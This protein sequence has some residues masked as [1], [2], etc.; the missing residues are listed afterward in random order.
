[1]KD[2][3]GKEVHVPVAPNEE[4]LIRNALES[5]VVRQFVRLQVADIYPQQKTPVPLA[6]LVKDDIAETIKSLKAGLAVDQVNLIAIQPPKDVKASFDEVLQ[7]KQQAVEQRTRADQERQQTLIRAAGAVG[8]A[9]GDEIEKWWA[10]K[11]A[12]NAE[13]VKKSDAVI[14]KLFL[15]AGGEVQATESDISTY[16]IAAAK[17]IGGDV[18]NTISDARAY[19]IT[20]VESARGDAAQVESLAKLLKTSPHEVK[21]FLDQA[22]VEA[23]QE[24]L[25]NAYETY[26]YHSGAG[27]KTKSSL[28][29][30]LGRRAEL[31]RDLT[32]VKE[33]R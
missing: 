10:A 1:V 29:L 18:Q 26:L 9:L 7:A 20:A 4:V 24:M 25:D 16:K 17:S 15:I 21:I 5:A 13:D 2:E 6:Q 33:T 31:L 3:M 27:G 11:A 32:Q 19:Q 14:H 22:R 8:V 28:E 30:W 12:G 23:L